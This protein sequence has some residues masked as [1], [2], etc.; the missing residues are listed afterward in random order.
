MKI[1]REYINLEAYFKP[2]KALVILG[3][4]QSGKTTLLNDFLEK[5]KQIGRAHV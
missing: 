2:N 1:P 5:T 3:P 4:R